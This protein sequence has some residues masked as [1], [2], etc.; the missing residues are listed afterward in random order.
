MNDALG[1]AMQQRQDRRTQQNQR[2]T[3]S[4]KQKMLHHVD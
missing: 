1:E 3:Y 2:S 4:H